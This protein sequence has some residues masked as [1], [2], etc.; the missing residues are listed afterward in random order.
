MIS[1]FERLCGPGKPLKQEPADAREIEC[2]QRA[3]LAKLEDAAR[4]ELAIESRFDLAYNASHALCVA[5]LRAHGYRASNRYIVFQLLPH[6]LGLGPEIWRV[7]SRCHDL[8]NLAE[9]EGEVNV[10]ES[11]VAELIAICKGLSDQ[12]NKVKPAIGDAGP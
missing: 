2:L 5:A 11:L 10:T 3:A 1:A 6:T 9:Y 7:L 8:R 4:A 12:L